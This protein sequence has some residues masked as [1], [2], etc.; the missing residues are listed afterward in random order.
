[1]PWWQKQFDK[2]LVVAALLIF[3]VLNYRATSA[4]FLEHSA[5]LALGCLLGMVRAKDSDA[6]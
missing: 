4:Q 2:L 1:M 5:D 3:L 6:Q